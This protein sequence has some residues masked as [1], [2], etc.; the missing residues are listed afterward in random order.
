VV[1]LEGNPEHPHSRRET[2]PHAANR[3]MMNTYDPICVL[4]PLIR[5]GK[6]GEGKFRKAT[7]DEALDLTASKMLDIRRSMEQR[8]WCSRPRTT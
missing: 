2:V 4:T 3:A 5:A 7:W 1:K 8:P 6:R